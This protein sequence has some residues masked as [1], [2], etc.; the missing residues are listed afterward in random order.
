MLSSIH[1]RGRHPETLIEA[2]D[3]L[4]Q[5]RELPQLP[6]RHPL[7]GRRALP[8]LRIPGRSLHGERP[9]LAVLRE[10]RTAAVQLEDRH[11]IE[12]SPITLW[13]WLAAIW[14]IVNCKNG[15]SSYEIHRRSG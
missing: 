12:E 14:M 10:A 9:A 7:A 5:V 11:H 2:L 1:G 8:A 3:L 4:R 13:K 6:G 15:I